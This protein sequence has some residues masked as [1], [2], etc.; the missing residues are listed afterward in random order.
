MAVLGAIGGTA[1]TVL[2]GLI[3]R[4]PALAEAVDKR[5]LMLM[6]EYKSTIA[7][8]RHEVKNLEEKVKDLTTE[9][10][11]AQAPHA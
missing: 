1:G 3:N 7:D 5:I 4:Q 8:L 9:L 11:L 10:R 6:E 2:L